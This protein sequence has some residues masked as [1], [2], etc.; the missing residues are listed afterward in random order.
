MQ[1]WTH[2]PSSFRVDALVLP[3][4]PKRGEYWN[5][6]M[7]NFRYRE[8]APMLWEKV[9]TDQF[10]WCCTVRGLFFRVTEDQDL[11]EW[12]ISAPPCKIIAYVSSPVWEDLVWSRS[13]S[14]D[15]LFIKD[16]PTLGHKDINA[17]A[18]VPLPSGCVKRHGQLPPKH[19]REQMERA[20]ELVR[21][22]PSVDP[23]LLEEHDFDA[24]G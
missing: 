10:L 23:K 20:A 4:D 14:W 3:I 18:S 13:D 8:V 22:R 21:N 11:V 24:D 17:L 15:D 2:H 16:A 19:T 7:G 9:G 5:Q 6:Q 12:E 1:L